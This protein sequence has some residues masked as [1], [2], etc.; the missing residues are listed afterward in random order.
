MPNN[1][2]SIVDTY[3]VHPSRREL[4]GAALSPSPTPPDVLPSS[5][6]R[7]YKTSKRRAPSPSDGLQKRRRLSST[8]SDSDGETDI[9]SSG[10]TRPSAD[11]QSPASSCTLGEEIE[12]FLEDLSEQIYINAL[13]HMCPENL[14]GSFCRNPQACLENNRFFACPNYATLK[15][16]QHGE[17][18]TFTHFGHKH[19]VP[20]CQASDQA[21]CNKSH[22]EGQACRIK[23]VYYHIRASCV[24]LR[25]G[26]YCQKA[27]CL[28]GHD[29]QLIRKR[30]M[31]MRK[32]ESAGT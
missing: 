20:G 5:S 32:I 16:C 30:V 9:D 15:V 21:E 17:N 29:Y 11:S 26:T 12:T 7:L 18:G 22:A 4:I 8:R 2:H 27:P 19:T 25:G 24:T 1:P 6:I 23:V 10:S 14:R 13:S 28:W 3:S 31:S